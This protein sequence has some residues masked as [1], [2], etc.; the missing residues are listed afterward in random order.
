MEKQEDYVRKYV[1]GRGG[2][3]PRRAGQGHS[4]P[5]GVAPL[6]PK[7]HVPFGLKRLS[8]VPVGMKRFSPVLSGI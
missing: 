1:E 7:T 6:A 5:F 2:S 3:K 8:P 4:S